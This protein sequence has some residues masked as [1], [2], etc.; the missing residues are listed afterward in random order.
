MVFPDDDDASAFGFIEAK[1][2]DERF[3]GGVTALAASGE[4]DYLRA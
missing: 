1:L 2:V 4:D 3:S